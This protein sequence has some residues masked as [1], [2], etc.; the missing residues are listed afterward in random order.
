MKVKH[1]IEQLQKLPQE[2]FIV[3]QLPHIQSYGE[4]RGFF[5]DAHTGLVGIEIAVVPQSTQVQP[6]AV[7]P[8]EAG[9]RSN[10]TGPKAH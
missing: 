3:N 2:A 10:E 9:P 7:Q 6:G 8:T 4:C 5:L 1:A